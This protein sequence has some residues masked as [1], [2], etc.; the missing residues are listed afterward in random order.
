[1]ALSKG[2]RE[3]LELLNSR[4]V[5]LVDPPHLRLNIPMPHRETTEPYAFFFLVLPYGISSGFVSHQI[6]S[7]AA[8][9]KLIVTA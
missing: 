4:G 7:E 6:R 5:D 8:I 2:W 9:A 1:M 3:F